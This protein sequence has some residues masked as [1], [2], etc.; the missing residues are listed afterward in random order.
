MEEEGIVQKEEQEGQIN[1]EEV[2]D[3]HKNEEN[4]IIAFSGRWIDGGLSR[5]MRTP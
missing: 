2:D 3:D 5:Y 1:I 4:Q